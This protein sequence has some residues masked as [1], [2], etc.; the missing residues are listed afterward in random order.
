M[1]YA[2]NY[3]GV[4][5]NA[6]ALF[7]RKPSRQQL[8]VNKVLD[9]LRDQDFALVCETHST[10]GKAQAEAHRFNQLGYTC[11]W[12]HGGHKRA[13]VGVIIKNTFLQQFDLAAP[14][15]IQISPGEAAVLQL[16]GPNGQLDICSIYFPTGNQARGGNSLLQLRSALRMKIAQILRPAS[17]AL[18]LVGGDFNYVTDKVDRWSKSGS[19]WSS[20]PD[21]REETDWA[22]VL[23]ASGQLHELYQPHGTHDNV[24]ARSRLDRVYSSAGVADQLDCHLGCAPLEWCK[25]LSDHRPVLFFRHAS[26]NAQIGKNTVPEGPVNHSSWPRRVA[27]EFGEQMRR[28]DSPQCALRQLAILKQSMSDVTHAMHADHVQDTLEQQAQETDDRLGW[29]IRCFRAVQHQRPQTVDRCILAYPALAKLI[30]RSGADARTNGRLEPLKKHIEELARASVLEE[31][32]AIQADNGVVDEHVQKNRRAKA[33][34]R[35]NKLRPGNS[36]SIAA[37]KCADGSMATTPEAIAEE[38]RIYW[39]EV[40]SHR[41]HDAGTLNQWFQEELCGQQVFPQDTC[42]DIELQNVEH[43]LKV[44]PSTAPGPDGIPYKAWKRLGPLAASILLGAIHKLGEENSHTALCGMSGNEDASAHMFNLGNMVFLPKKPAGTDPVLGDYFTPAD[45]RPLVIVNTDNRIMANAVRHRLEPIFADW[46]SDSQQGFIKGRSMLANVLNVVHQAQVTSLEQEQGAILLFDFK[47]AFPSLCHGY[48]FSVLK[49]L[50]IPSH[51]YNFI[52]M[53]YD[54]HS[55]HISLAGG[56]Y[57]GFGIHAGIRQGCPL[58]PLLFALVVDILLRRIGRLRPDLMVRAFADDIA[59]VAPKLQDCIPTLMRLFEEVSRVA[60]LGLNLP[61]C[62]LIPL[63]PID[64]D[65][66]SIEFARRFPAWA[67]ISVRDKGTYLGFAV[68]PAAGDS[69][70]DKPLRKFHDCAKWWGRSGVGLHYATVAY[71]TYALPILSFVGQLCAPPR[72]AFEAEEKALRAMCPGPGNWCSI[73]DLHT[74]SEG[75]GQP[76]SFPSLA[77][78]CA[79][80]QMRVHQW[81]NYA[82]G[83]LQVQNKIRQ[84][85]V[86]IAQSDL[87]D[88]YVRWF[89]WYTTGP[90]ATLHNNSVTLE[91]TG[92]GASVLLTKAGWDVIPADNMEAG[93][94]RVR[95]SFQKCVRVA[96]LKRDQQAPVSRI[97]KKLGRWNLTGN[98][99]ATSN[100]CAR[101]F[102]D[103]KGLFPPRVSAAIWKTMWNGWTTARRFQRNA[104]CLLCCGGVCGEDSIEHYAMCSV[105]RKVGRCFVGLQD[106]HYSTWLGNF[107]A[108]GLNQGKVDEKTLTLRAS[109][110]YAVFRTTNALRHNPTTSREVAHD[111]LVQ[112]AKEAVRGHSKATAYLQGVS[113]T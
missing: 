38:L 22:S 24:N 63:W 25:S 43:A 85:Q 81:E 94:R 15:W 36:S 91:S 7:S 18:S 13:G 23:E 40:F 79:A 49:A 34:V 57:R 28:L 11:F 73:L 53:L 113:S 27:L 19:D 3:R 54:N 31:L 80:S 29:A 95:K 108:L 111:M 107:V 1:P 32:Q 50:G 105:V 48:L 97:R 4:L 17:L 58:S 71:S 74:M 76:R 82:Q 51:I 84:L 61:K 35:L 46:I 87:M 42:W 92:L 64:M 88:R 103:F 45:V 101:A 47:A 69:S 5:W 55:C 112:F 62:V 44:A 30:V 90:V 98:P 2:G 16:A 10:K 86:V 65:I 67:A 9:L 77:H 56:M 110:V 89:S 52:R 8:K 72:E 37:I 60:G 12:S 102:Q 78:M 59:I 106:S 75:F 104:D 20:M 100:R 33:Q 39:G 83:G 6:Q 66:V 26:G 70:W 14:R 93:V 109:L 41:E 21:H 96:L 68:G 99:N